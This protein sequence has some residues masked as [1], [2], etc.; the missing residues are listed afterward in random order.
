MV[1]CKVKINATK[2][3]CKTLLLFISVS[4]GL[5]DWDINKNLAKMLLNFDWHDSQSTLT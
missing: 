4:F 2:A 1:W 3:I 5:A